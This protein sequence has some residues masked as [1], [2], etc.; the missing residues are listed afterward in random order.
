VF[1][2]IPAMRCL[3]F[4]FNVQQSKRWAKIC[5]TSGDG[6]CPVS[7]ALGDYVDPHYLFWLPVVQKTAFFCR[8]YY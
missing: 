3:H 5:R 7:T 4:V 8:D 2:S 6:R 1:R